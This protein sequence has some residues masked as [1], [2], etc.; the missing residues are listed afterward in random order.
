[1]L[2]DV[3]DTED[4]P[5]RDRVEAWREITANALVPNEFRVDPVSGFRASLRAANLGGAQVAAMTYGSHRTR[6]TPG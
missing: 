4:L 5:V 6:R 1:M 3:F 2:G